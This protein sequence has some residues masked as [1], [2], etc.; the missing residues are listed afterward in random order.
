[1]KNKKIFLLL[2]VL[3]L[4]MSCRT[5]TKYEEV[6]KV[7]YKESKNYGDYT[8]NNNV[9]LMEKKDKTYYRN[10]SET[11]K[12]ELFPDYPDEPNSVKKFIYNFIKV[13]SKKEPLY[14]K[15]DEDV[16]K[17]DDYVFFFVKKENVGNMDSYLYISI[18]NRSKNWFHMGAVDFKAASGEFVRINF[19]V[20]KLDGTSYWLDRTRMDSSTEEYVAFIMEDSQIE[21]LVNLLEENEKIDIILYSDYS[22]IKRTRELSSTE[23]ENM[24]KVYEFYKYTKE[25]KDTE[26]ESRN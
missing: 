26:E 23:R 13:D 5:A 6:V 16:F 24:L 7:G 25:N 12:K 20:K 21:K 9:N 4:L 2:F 18:K 10:L 22:D 11:E 14:Y 17:K 1:M 3:L 8:G 19:E 15:L